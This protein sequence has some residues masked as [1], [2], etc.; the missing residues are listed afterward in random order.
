MRNWHLDTDVHSPLRIRHE[1][2]NASIM[3]WNP[4]GDSMY[5]MVGRRYPVP[6]MHSMSK[7]SGCDTPFQHDANATRG[8]TGAPVVL[9]AMRPSRIT[10]SSSLSR[11]C[12]PN[13]TTEYDDVM[14]LLA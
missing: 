6:V 1:F 4:A 10:T 7:K 12:C 3:K 13:T 8:N 9:K 2:R 14:A 11:S 5:V